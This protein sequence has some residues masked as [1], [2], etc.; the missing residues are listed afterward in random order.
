MEFIAP[1]IV[2]EA[3]RESAPLTDLERKMLYVSAVDEST[4]VTST[5]EQ[6]DPVYDQNQYEKKIAR[7]IKKADRRLRAENREEYDRWRNAARLVAATD[8]YL[9][10]MIARAN[11]RPPGDF[12]K[13]VAAGVAVVCLLMASIVVIDK[14]N[15]DL[16]SP[17][18]DAVGFYLWATVA[19]LGLTYWLLH[20][21]FGDRFDQVIW[22]MAEKLFRLPRNAK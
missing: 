6:F 18:R 10:V 8:H 13:L 12:L 3:E 5:C 11:L 2:E 21:V 4:D 7:L 15:I 20:L 9:S 16:R 17:S 19:S 22:N 14:Y 1:R